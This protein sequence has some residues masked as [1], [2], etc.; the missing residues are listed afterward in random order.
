[1]SART[2]KPGYSKSSKNKTIEEAFSVK[3]I[4]VD[5]DRERKKK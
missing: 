3:E 5:V 1:M 4:V 2:R